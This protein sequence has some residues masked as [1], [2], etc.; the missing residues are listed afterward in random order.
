MGVLRVSGFGEFRPL[1]C[2]GLAG[3]PGDVLGTHQVEQRPGHRISVAGW[4]AQQASW[5]TDSILWCKWSRGELCP[6]HPRSFLLINISFQHNILK[7]ILLIFCSL[8]EKP[9]CIGKEA[10]VTKSKRNFVLKS[11]KRK[12]R[13]LFFFFFLSLPLVWKRKH[14]DYFTRLHDPGLQRWKKVIW[15]QL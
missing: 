13:T 2:P 6:M 14:T 1:P 7:V 11:N 12:W 4:K 3:S 5:L 8:R 15:M 9:Y 10:C